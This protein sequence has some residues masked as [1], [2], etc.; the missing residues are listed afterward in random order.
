MT[1]RF[2][3]FRTPLR[4]DPAITRAAGGPEV[5]VEGV[6]VGF[7]FERVA[8]GIS[9][10]SGWLMKLDINRRHKENNSEEQKS[11]KQR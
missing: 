3:A 11:E 9:R 10:S 5:E 4:R 8:R 7:G 1:L 2:L 6:G